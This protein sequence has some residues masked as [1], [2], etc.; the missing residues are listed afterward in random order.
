MFSLLVLKPTDNTWRFALWP[1]DL[2]DDALQ[3]GLTHFQDFEDAIQSTK[4]LH[5]RLFLVRDLLA[6]EED[7]R[8]LTWLTFPQAAKAWTGPQR[9]ILLLAVQFLMAGGRIE[10]D[11]LATTAEEVLEL[12]EPRDV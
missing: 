6:F 7:R 5:V 10:D 12:L 9:R 3:L 2:R 8:P 1:H 11:V 4:K